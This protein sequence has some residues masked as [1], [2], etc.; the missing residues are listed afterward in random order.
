MYSTVVLSGMGRSLLDGWRRLTRVAST[1]LFLGVGEA[2]HALQH[3]EGPQNFDKCV[4]GM[5]VAT[6]N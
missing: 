2:L 4:E 5:N 6:F 3:P 1:L